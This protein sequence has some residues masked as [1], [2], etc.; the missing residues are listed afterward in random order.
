[1]TKYFT[2]IWNDPLMPRIVAGDVAAF[3]E[4]VDTNRYRMAA[5]K[6]APPSTDILTSAK[7]IQAEAA[8]YKAKEGIVTTK[9][10]IVPGLIA[11][12]ERL[13][14]ERTILLDAL[15]KHRVDLLE[16]GD[17]SP[18]PVAPLYK[19]TSYLVGIVVGMLITL[20]PIFVW[21]MW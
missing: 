15:Q 18:D 1:M 2:S 6:A 13:R 11:E 16:K 8:A 19:D 3:K 9:Q 10:G 21:K 4:W 20:M 17:D 7:Q 5:S 14:I 12:V